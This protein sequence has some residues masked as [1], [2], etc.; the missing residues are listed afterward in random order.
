LEINAIKT[1]ATAK[2]KRNGNRGERK[3]ASEFQ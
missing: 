1:A 2:R 3:K